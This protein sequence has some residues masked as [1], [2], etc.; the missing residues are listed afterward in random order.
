[1]NVTYLHHSLY[2]VDEDWCLYSALNISGCVVR[3]CTA[4]LSLRKI[5]LSLNL[6]CGGHLGVFIS[7]R[8]RILL[9]EC[10]RELQ[11]Y[12]VQLSEDLINERW[13]ARGVNIDIGDRGD[14]ANKCSI[15]GVQI[16]EC[17]VLIKGP[18]MHHLV[19]WLHRGCEQ[20]GMSGNAGR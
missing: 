15:V 4:L 20:L 13:L 11:T 8:G 18:V 14:A 2:A 10:K 7:R 9:A 17:T 16:L 12:A 3:K 19:L 5:A 6:L 1:M